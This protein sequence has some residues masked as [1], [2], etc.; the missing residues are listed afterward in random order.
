M[1]A[2]KL[3]KIFDGIFQT[4]HFFSLSHISSI[5]FF[6]KKMVE[7]IIISFYLI[8]GGFVWD[9]HNWIIITNFLDLTF[10]SQFFI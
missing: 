3:R 8:K 4:Q 10:F 5:Y 2:K 6:W 9:S 7:I 1:M